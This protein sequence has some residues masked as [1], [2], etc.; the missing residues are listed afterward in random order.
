M[1]EV[2]HRGL[3]DK[4]PLSAR[5]ISSLLA[6]SLCVS[7]STRVWYASFC[8]PTFCLPNGGV[9]GSS[10]EIGISVMVFGCLL[11]PSRL[12]LKEHY[13]VDRSIRYGEL[14]FCWRRFKQSPNASGVQTCHTLDGQ[15]LRENKDVPSQV[16]RRNMVRSN[17]A[18]NRRGSLR[19]N[20][21]GREI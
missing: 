6:K 21:R 7:Q 15:R 9:A 20:R 3:K 16:S 8:L 11:G 19:G 1:R 5:G 10:E 18:R 12:I 17:L 2:L 14:R 13:A 4:Q